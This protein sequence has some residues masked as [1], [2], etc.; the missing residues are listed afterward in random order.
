[1]RVNVFYDQGKSQL[2][3]MKWV[4]NTICKFAIKPTSLFVSLE[5]F[6]EGVGIARDKM[7]NILSAG[8]QQ[9]T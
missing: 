8:I 2:F 4:F 6:S 3:G 1:M 9:V 5:D 7:S